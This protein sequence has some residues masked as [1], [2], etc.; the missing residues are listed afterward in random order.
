MS[1]VRALRRTCVLA[2]MISAAAIKETRGERRSSV[3]T[4]RLRVANSAGT[5]QIVCEQAALA[6]CRGAG[7]RAFIK[8]GATALPKAGLCAR[9]PVHSKRHAEETLSTKDE[10]QGGRE[11]SH[12]YSPRANP[13]AHRRNGGRNSPGF[14]NGTS[15]PCRRTQRVGIFSCRSGEANQRRHFS[16]FHRGLELWAPDRDVGGSEAHA[17]S[18]FEHRGENRYRGG[19]YPRYGHDAAIFVARIRAAQAETDSCGGFAGQARAPHRQGT[20][21]LRWLYH[22]Q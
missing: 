19:R 20:R 13:A 22:P 1:L 18:G 3:S 4:R 11:R 14:S 15:A 6:Q 5:R 21:R 7:S 17:R 9:V 16:G 10:A 12:A 2:S 8:C